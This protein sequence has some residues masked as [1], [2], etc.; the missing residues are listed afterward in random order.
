MGFEVFDTGND[1]RFSS[2]NQRY[3]G[4]EGETDRLSFVWFS[5]IEEGSPD[6]GDNPKFVGAQRLYHPE[7]GY[8]LDD[9]PEFNKVSVATGGRPSKL[10]VATVVVQWP[11]DRN[12]QLEKNRFSKGDFTVLPWI[13]S[14]D[15]YQSLKKV[16]NRFHFGSHDTSVDCSDSQY[17]KM[18][19][20]SER[21]NLLS[22]L[23]KKNPDMAEKI[24]SQARDVISGIENSIAQTL[25]IEEFKERLG[26]GEKESFEGMDVSDSDI[27]DVMDDIL[28]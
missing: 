4:R 24:L 18:S 27:T 16:H 22:I 14:K 28:G 11:T 9:G 13:F 15:K 2:K 25:T 21:D 26:R 20:I 3:K 12:G 1:N 10:A 19:F 8:V 23:L 6:L 17:Q 7:V 5:G